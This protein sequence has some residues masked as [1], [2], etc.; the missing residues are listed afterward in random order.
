MKT[1]SLDCP[2]KGFSDALSVVESLRLE[3]QEA[4]LDVLQHR[5]AE[6]RRAALIREAAASRRDHKKGRVRRGDA[7]ALMAELRGA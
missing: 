7:A 1:G 4:L 2:A 3:D 6:T 5:L